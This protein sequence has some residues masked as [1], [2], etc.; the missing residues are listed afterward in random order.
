MTVGSDVASSTGVTIAVSKPGHSIP[1]TW[2]KPARLAW[3]D[4]FAKQHTIG[5][6]SQHLRKKLD[7][8]IIGV[9]CRWD[10]I[11]PPL[12]LVCSLFVSETRSFHHL[13]WAPA[14]KLARA[15]HRLGGWRQSALRPFRRLS[16]HPPCRHNQNDIIWSIVLLI[17]PSQ[18]VDRNSLD[19]CFASMTV[20]HSCAIQ[21]H[22]H[23]CVA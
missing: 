12:R 13:D 23:S 5:L 4:Q 14:Y 17:E 18:I 9:R 1:W 21:R 22:S 8:G 11:K 20:F 6:H 2:L 15:R 3:F 10:V 19:I 7:G 16:F